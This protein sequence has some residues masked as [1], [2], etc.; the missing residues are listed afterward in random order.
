MCD[1]LSDSQ[2]II[3][4]PRLGLGF[5]FGLALV[6]ISIR[7]LFE[8]CF[9]RPVCL[10]KLVFFLPG[11]TSASRTFEGLWLM[12]FFLKAFI[13]NSYCRKRFT[14][15]CYSM[16]RSM[17]EDHVFLSNMC[18]FYSYSSLFVLLG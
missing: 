8:P 4:H 2:K 9:Y 14:H 11:Q 12:L 10:E 15:G 3:F 6:G 18:Q 16:S 7:L 17:D 13:T 5:R 1:F